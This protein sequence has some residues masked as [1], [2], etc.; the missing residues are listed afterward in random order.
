MVFY[1]TKLYLAYRV[2]NDSEITGLSLGSSNSGATIYTNKGTTY[3]L[4]DS[5]GATIIAESIYKW[6]G[7]AF[8][9]ES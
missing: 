2:N 1:S 4:T 6:N 8:V 5:T 7:T 3:S 9:K